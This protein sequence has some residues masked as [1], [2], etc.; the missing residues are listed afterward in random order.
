MPR[1]TQN[2]DNL[3]LNEM[4]FGYGS[5]KIVFVIRSKELGL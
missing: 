1:D 3:P 4:R 2:K 5:P